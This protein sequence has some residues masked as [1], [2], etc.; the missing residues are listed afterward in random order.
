MNL[1]VLRRNIVNLIRRGRSVELR[2]PMDSGGRVN[3]SERSK[4]VSTTPSGSPMSTVAIMEA[5]GGREETLSITPEPT[6]GQSASQ[7]KKKQRQF[8][9]SM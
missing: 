9:I 7:E 2:H 1:G 3:T 6:A 8:D 5:E 4:I